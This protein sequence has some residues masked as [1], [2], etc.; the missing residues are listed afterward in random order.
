VE[1]PDV[2]GREGDVTDE[3]QEVVDAFWQHD[4]SQLLR[5]SLDENET[6]LGRWARTHGP[7]TGGIPNLIWRMSHCPSPSWI[8]FQER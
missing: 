7:R 1:D 2:S 6:A 4:L 8:V 3:D 5:A